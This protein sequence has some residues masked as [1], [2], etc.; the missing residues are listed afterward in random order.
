MLA[1]R[2]IIRNLAEACRKEYPFI[3]SRLGRATTPRRICVVSLGERTILMV[4]SSTF[5]IFSF[6]LCPLLS[7]AVMRR[8]LDFWPWLTLM[9]ESG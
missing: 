6:T 7:R 9:A 4:F 3:S 2:T 8:R 1:L 5:F